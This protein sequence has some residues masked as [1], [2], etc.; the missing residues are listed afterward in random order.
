MCSIQI[1]NA[2]A[3]INV[4]ESDRPYLF[5]PYMFANDFAGRIA[6]H[7]PLAKMMPEYNGGFWRLS[8]R[9]I[10]RIHDARL[11]SAIRSTQKTGV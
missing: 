3:A 5:L 6:S 8:A 2:S 7:M 9:R 11:R 4:E 10:W 1:S